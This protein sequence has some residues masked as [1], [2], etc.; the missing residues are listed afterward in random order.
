MKN[1]GGKKVYMTAEEKRKKVTKLK[2]RDKE[3][4]RKGKSRE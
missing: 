3:K 4:K 2:G 1:R